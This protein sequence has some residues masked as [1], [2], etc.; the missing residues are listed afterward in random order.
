VANLDLY[1][2]R[3][4]NSMVEAAGL[5]GAA[6]LLCEAVR[7]HADL[8]DRATPDPAEMEAAAARVDQA[9]AAYAKTLLSE[10]GW[11]VSFEPYREGAY[12]KYDRLLAAH[13]AVGGG[14]A[15]PQAAWPVVI[16]RFEIQIEDP[17]GLLDYAHSRL[18][19]EFTEPSEALRLLCA[20]DGWAPGAY[21][22]GLLSVDDH[23]VATLPAQR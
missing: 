16:D 19:G 13:E 21:R 6:E 3:E 4:R 20:E 8:H 12:P 9:A 18:G 15:P 23:S 10:T 11:G 17:D 14:L 22:H 7:Q 5:Q 1:G 2:Q